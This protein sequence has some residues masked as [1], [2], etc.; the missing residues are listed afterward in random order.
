MQWW[1]FCVK[2]QSKKIPSFSI[3]VYPHAPEQ[4]LVCC[5][6]YSLPGVSMGNGFICVG[7]AH[8]FSKL[9]DLVICGGQEKKKRCKDWFC[10]VMD[11]TVDF[12][13]AVVTLCSK[14][15]FV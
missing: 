9:Q 2:T 4:R 8:Q 13:Q 11:S 15:V 10:A 3:C 6:R 14:V 5:H 7:G 1:H 12:I